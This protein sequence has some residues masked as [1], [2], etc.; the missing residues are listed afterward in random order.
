MY[1][2]EK[3]PEMG[4]YCI[5]LDTRKVLVKVQ[6]YTP[7]ASVTQLAERWVDNPEVD[8]SSPSAATFGSTYVSYVNGQTTRLRTEKWGFDSLRDDHFRRGSLTIKAPLLQ[9]TILLGQPSRT[10]WVIR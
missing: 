5:R 6:P 7:N 10:R 3:A 4:A 2:A 9:R 1:V 8:G